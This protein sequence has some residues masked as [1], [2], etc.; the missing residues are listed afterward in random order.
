MTHACLLQ[1]SHSW[2]FAQ[3][4]TTISKTNNKAVG[5][6]LGFS[7]SIRQVFCCPK[8]SA[9]QMLEWQ[10]FWGLGGR[11]FHS[12]KLAHGG[13]QQTRDLTVPTVCLFNADT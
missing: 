13:E 5:L 12:G 3:S 7:T 2:F 4:P 11:V 8:V 1:F 10:W 6:Y 9:S